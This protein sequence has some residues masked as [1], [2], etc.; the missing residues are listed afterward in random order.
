[1]AKTKRRSCKGGRRSRR[2]RGGVLPSYNTPYHAGPKAHGFGENPEGVSRIGDTRQS[3]QLLQIGPTYEDIND[4]ERDAKNYMRMRRIR[5]F[6]RRVSA[7][8]RNAIGR[9][10]SAARGLGAS[11]I[12]KIGFNSHYLDHSNLVTVPQ[13]RKY[14]FG[15]SENSA[16]R[17]YRLDPRTGKLYE[18][19]SKYL[20][21]VGYWPL[22]RKNEMTAKFLP[23]HE[24]K[25]G[26][27]WAIVNR[28][29]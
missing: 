3:E 18:T 15:L 6:G 28:T 1:M 12:R 8:A 20:G 10:A 2:C 16:E 26:E 27:T 24:P 21:P 19:N 9:T 13:D 11:A 23:G 5:E 22:P 4:I 14:N 25:K 17:L 7:S 29:D